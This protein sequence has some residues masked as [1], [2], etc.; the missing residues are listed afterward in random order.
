[1]GRYWCVGLLTRTQIEL[2]AKEFG[3]VQSI[4]PRYTTALAA[5]PKR[6]GSKPSTAS[7][8]LPTRPVDVMQLPTVAIVDTGIPE[9]HVTLA[10]Y[11][12]SGYRN[13]DLD[14]T[15]KSI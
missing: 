5:L 4:H 3:S 6:G 1:S 13:P 10:P 7:A 9:Q 14:P 2:I 11:R 15:I 8:E 12:R